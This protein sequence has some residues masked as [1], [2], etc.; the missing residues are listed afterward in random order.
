MGTSKFYPYYHYD[1]RLRIGSAFRHALA[2]IPGPI[3]I[4]PAAFGRLDDP[5]FA[6]IVGLALIDRLN[7]YAS[8]VLGVEGNPTPIK[9]VFARY[10]PSWTFCQNLFQEWYLGDELYVQE[11]GHAPI[12]NGKR[13][14][15]YLERPLL[16]VETLR[17]TLALYV[18]VAMCWV[19]LQAAPAR[20]QSYR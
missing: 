1:L 15:I 17:T 8:Y 4:T 9:G 10:S 19:L 14:V 12:Q 11:A 20:K 5:F 13:G 18:N 2:Q 7:D 16:P 6:G 3:E